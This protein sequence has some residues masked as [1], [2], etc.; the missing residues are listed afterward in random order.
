MVEETIDGVTDNRL[1]A[2]RLQFRQPRTGYRAAI[3]PVLLAAAV[4]AGFGDSVVDLGCGAGAAML[5]LAARVDTVRI[6]GLDLDQ[7]LVALARDNLAANRF[8]GRASAD[9]GDVA[10]PPGWLSLGGFDHVMANPPYLQPGLVTVSPDPR[11]AGADV[12]GQADLEA[13]IGAA[14]RLLRPKGW[15]TLIH[16]ADRIDALCTRLTGG[17]GGIEVIPLWPR[18]GVAA[19]RVIVRARKAVRSPA[20][21]SPGLV[22]HE[23]DGTFTELAQSVLRDGG[24][25]DAAIARRGEEG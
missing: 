11:K 16:R 5:C 25:L 10:A 21:L 12:E 17:F 8:T 23:A 13:W 4:P 24:S 22:L 2:G 7:D 1:L 20:V 3:D 9:V 19:R 14:H 18:Q 6:V 15:F